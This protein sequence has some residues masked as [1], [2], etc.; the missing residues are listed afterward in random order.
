MEKND[1]YADHK[2]SHKTK[3]A[4]L[5]NEQIVNDIWVQISVLNTS[6]CKS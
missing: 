1:I 4:R 2:S 6:H 5:I 3:L